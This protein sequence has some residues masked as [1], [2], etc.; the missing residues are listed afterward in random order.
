[1]KRGHSVDTLFGLLLFCLF[2]V[3]LLTTLMYGVNAY[4]GITKSM[5]SQFDQRTALSYL[6]AK[7]RHYDAVNSV[8]VEP[9]GGETA[10]C[11]REKIDGETYCTWIYRQNGTMMELFAAEESELTPESGQEILKTGEL[12]FR[13]DDTQLVISCAGEASAPSEL[14]LFLR[15]EGKVS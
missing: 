6:A 2:A 11:L 4:R 1:M 13:M 7:V 8:S 15:S 12:N 3:L 9:F 5:Q 10:L 14:R